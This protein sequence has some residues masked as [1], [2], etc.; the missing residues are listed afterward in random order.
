[1]TRAAFLGGLLVAGLFGLFGCTTKSAALP[2]PLGGSPEAWAAISNGAPVRT[3]VFLDRGARSNGAF[4]WLELSTSAEGLDAFPVNAEMIRAGVLDRADL[5][6]MP[7]GYSVTEAKTLGAEGREKVRAFLRRGGSWIGTCA[8]AFLVSQSSK[9]HPD[10]LDVMPYTS[11]FAGGR[12]EMMIAFNDDA[13]KLCGI[14]PKAY[15]IKYSGGPVLVPSNRVDGADFKVIARYDSDINVFGP[16][17]RETMAEKAAVLAGTYGRGRVWASA[18]HPEV[19]LADHHVLEG[20]FRFVTGRSI[21]W[22]LPRRKPGQLAVGVCTDDSLGVAFGRKL[23][24]LIRARTYDLIPIC[25]SDIK[26]GALRHLD[27]LVAADVAETGRNGCVGAKFSIAAV[28]EFRARGGAV[29]S[30]GKA[31]ALLTKKNVGSEDVASLDGLLKRLA[32]LA[33]EPVET[34]SRIVPKKNANPVKVA[35]YIGKG[36]SCY[37]IAEMLAFSPEFELKVVSPEDVQAGALAGADL[38]LQPGGGCN[39]QML[40]LGEKGQAEVR[41]FVEKGGKYYGVCAGAFLATQSEGKFKRLGLVPYKHDGEHIYRGWAPTN[42]KFTPEGCAA[43]GLKTNERM[44]LYWGGPV[45]VPGVPVPDSDV[46]V[47]GAYD[48]RIVNTCQP[49]PVAPMNGK[50]AFLGGRVGK[51]KVFVSAIHPEK[52]EHTC[53]IVHGGLNYLT[54][55]TPHPIARNRARGAMAVAMNLISE[56]PVAELMFSQL[57]P[58]RRFDWRIRYDATSLQHLDAVV[59]LKVRPE[60]VTADLAAFAKAGGRVIAVVD[61]PEAEKLVAPLA[62]VKKIRSI[63]QVVAAL[64]EGK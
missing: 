9:S 44:V 59:L 19:D 20:A 10:M 22:N 39:S 54:G 26:E 27:V 53:D 17:P 35:A 64:V 25:G 47:F 36:G 42:I 52:S 30:W 57:L 24:D 58:D 33:A 15:R 21:T 5:V 60:D 6:I 11:V 56:K 2:A 7:G 12:A 16:K 29:L 28:N 50:A 18:V 3:A 31:R 48:G 14:K 46:K 4:R 55:Q 45:M 61:T 32:A 13:E 51:G 8:G 62:G 41:K 43:L 38:L 23:Q 63:N 49:K 40:A 34:P 1:M 37:P